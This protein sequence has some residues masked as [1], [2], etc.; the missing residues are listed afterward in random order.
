MKA[1]LEAQGGV[2]RGLL[3]EENQTYPLPT[4]HGFNHV[5]GIGGFQSIDITLGNTGF[6]VVVRID[7][8]TSSPITQRDHEGKSGQVT[9]I[10]MDG[11]SF[12]GG[13]LG[14]LGGYTIIVTEAGDTKNL[15]LRRDILL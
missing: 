2:G 5:P 14:P 12:S 10:S 8:G 6:E 3:R 1:S 4:G 15:L 13:Q 7:S 11:T 9:R